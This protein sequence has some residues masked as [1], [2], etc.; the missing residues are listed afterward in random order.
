MF[1]I[2]LLF[3]VSLS[4]EYHYD[5]KLEDCPLEFRIDSLL[6]DQDEDSFRFFLTVISDDSFSTAKIEFGGDKYKDESFI[7]Y[8][9]YGTINFYKSFHQEHETV[10]KPG[11]YSLS[12]DVAK[13]YFPKDHHFVFRLYTI[14]GNTTNCYQFYQSDFKPYS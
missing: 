14:F 1:S 12:V 7:K 4:Q 2:V 6:Y 8:D 5:L 11:T 9:S 10:L 13:T 3:T